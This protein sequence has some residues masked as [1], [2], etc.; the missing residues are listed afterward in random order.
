MAER[1]E[2]RLIGEGW[3]LLPEG[4]DFERLRTRPDS[5]WVDLGHGYWCRASAIAEVRVVVDDEPEQTPGEDMRQRASREAR[6]EH[7]KPKPPDRSSYMG[8]S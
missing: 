2:I 4:L 7:D 6:E 8:E 3:R 5:E 1:V